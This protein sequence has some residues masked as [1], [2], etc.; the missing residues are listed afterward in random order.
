[1]YKKCGDIVEVE[2]DQGFPC[3]LLLLYSKTENKICHITTANLDGE[4]NIKVIEKKTN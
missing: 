2:R 3:D 1:M 4:T